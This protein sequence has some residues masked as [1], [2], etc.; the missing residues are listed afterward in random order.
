[1]L[2]AVNGISFENAKKIKN[3][4]ETKTRNDLNLF[5]NVLIPIS[6]PPS[7]YM[8]FLGNFSPP[9]DFAKTLEYNYF[10]LPKINID[11]K[12]YQIKPDKGQ[13]ECARKIYD[14]DTTILE[15]STGAGKTALAHYAVN[16]NLYDGKKTIITVPLV[17][18]ANDKY[19][20]FSKIY[21]K[22]N[23]GLLTGVTK[24][25]VN[26]PITIMV[27]E[28]L[29]NQA[30]SLNERKDEIGTI[31]FDEAH[32]IADKNRGAVWENSIISTIQN[33]I[34][35]LCL[36][37][38]LGNGDEFAHWIKS[39]NPNRPVSRVEINPS[40]R[41]VPLTY[42]IYKPFANEDNSGNF[43]PVIKG[44]VNLGEIDENN[45]TDKQ[46][47]ALGEIFKT[48]NKKNDFYEMSKEEY[49]TTFR[50]LK[51]KTSGLNRVFE[52]DEFKEKLE[53]K[54][55]ELDKN[56]REKIAQLLL[57]NKKVDRVRV[58][59]MPRGDDYPSLVKDLKREDLL[60]ALVF[61]LS[62]KGC[63]EIANSLERSDLDLTTDDEKDQ[64]RDTINDYKQKGVYFG[65]DFDENMLLRGYGVHHAGKMPG[66]QKLVEELFAKKLLKVV[67]ATST[68]S[69]GINMPVR[70][71]VMTDVTYKKFNPETK[72]LEYAPITPSEFHQM[73]GRAGR[74]GVDS[75]GHVVLY[76]IPTPKEGFLKDNSQ[77]KDRLAFAY[78]LIQSE[79]NKLISRFKPEACMMAQYYSEN[80]TNDNLFDVINKSFKVSLAKNPEKTAKSLKKK[81]E[82]Y[83]T[84]LLK[85]DFI[86][87]D[88]KGK[89]SLTPKGE[90]LK[91]A[92]G[93]NPIMLVSLIYDEK[94]KDVSAE[95]LCQISGYIASSDYQKENENS[96]A[97]IS[98]K[99]AS[100]LQD[101][102]DSADEIHKFQ[103]ARA[104]YQN[105]E[106]K[107]IKALNE[108]KLKADEIEI[109]DNFGGFVA[110]LWAHYN[111]Q[112]P[113]DS[114]S[115]FDLLLTDALKPIKDLGDS[116]SEN[117]GA[118]LEFNRK[119]APGHAYKIISQ[120]LSVLKQIERICDYAIENPGDYD[121][122]YYK[123]LK[124]TAHDALKLMKKPPIDEEGIAYEN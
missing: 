77:F 44:D 52:L 2:Q 123:N 119:A 30:Q 82:N 22:E 97:L 100:L 80:S 55:P 101:E 121:V 69:A 20:E 90:L 92:M 59:F 118:K 83:S 34:Q 73:T 11:G 29:R 88:N 51:I 86:E 91:S 17:S 8:S 84:I 45:L 4:I 63:D 49:I 35:A 60:P 15:A 98:E 102:N 27:T 38:T 89:I 72:T 61:K 6:P 95:Q 85:H 43:I 76:N 42:S 71:V 68:L 99:I 124:E 96:N 115:N 31:I 104:L 57:S 24:K 32:F 114:V 50:N 12:T 39:L 54:Y 3:N 48:Q 75:L 108:A 9:D 87:K 107:I 1:M 94:L 23:V 74:R 19:R 47:R 46:K 5:E 53:E 105:K 116:Q 109:S 25:N 66:Y 14:G 70:T 122:Q 78:D 81:F 40:E 112:N 26:A 58:D 110:Y 113:N 41:F 37:A 65:P 10:E 7:R 18:L 103:A 111:K 117:F 28:I 93:A 106:D 36:S 64:I 33:D 13:I 67:S 62:Q 56:Q 16:K 79:P 21:G 120:S